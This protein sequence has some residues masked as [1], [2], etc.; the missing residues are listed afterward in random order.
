VV[1][2]SG[3]KS[4]DTENTNTLTLYL[5]EEAA[6]YNRWIFDKISPWLGKRILEVG[7]GI[8]N[9]TGLL[10]GH[11]K[12]IAADVN[13]D[14][15]KIVENKFVNNSNLIKTIFWNI[16]EK[17]PENPCPAID[18]IVCSNVLEHIENDDSALK[19]FY[20]L[21]PAGGRLIVLVPALKILYNVLDQELGHFRRYNRKELI[22]KLTL[23]GFNVR[24]LKFFN[25][26]GILGWFV[27]GSLLRRRS[28]SKK[29]VR[30][31]NRMVPFFIRLEKGIPSFVGQS[32][33]AAGEK[34]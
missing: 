7:C 34:E 8:G 4:K 15:L 31:F 27:N 21:L 18:T 20:Q 17:F 12:V 25:F 24:Y 28:L 23:N 22:Q 33:I 9:L 2:N 16:Q 5:L 32:L 29:Q 6:A 30:I 19:N 3:L 10:L 14:Y 26:F 13:K 11:G 1:N